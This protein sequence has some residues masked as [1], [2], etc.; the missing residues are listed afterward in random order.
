M[1]RAAVGVGIPDAADRVV[2]LV[3]EHSR[4]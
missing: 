2:D 1:A 3:L 4:G